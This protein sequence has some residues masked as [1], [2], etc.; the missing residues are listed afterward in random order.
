MGVLTAG[1]AAG[2]LVF[3]PL[4][5]ALSDRYGWRSVSIAVTAAV[6]AVIPALVL[7]LPE[8]PEGVG[9]TPLGAI[10]R[11]IEA[12]KAR[13]PFLIAIQGL[14]R[15]VK[16]LDFWLLAIAFGVCGLSTNG[17]IGTHMIAYCV[18]GGYTELA[19]SSIL[20]SFGIFNIIGSTAAG[21]LTDRADPRLL[22][23]YIFVLRGLS[24]L[25]LPYTDLGPLS[26]AAFAV[27]YG[28]EWIAT[29][30]PIFA[31]INEV[32]GKRDAPVIVS[33]IFAVHQIGGAGAALGA[34]IIR[35]WAGSYLLAFVAT[36]VACLATAVLVLRIAR[37]Q[38]ELVPAT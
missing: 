5:G 38:R 19:A 11:P 20:A 36:G 14:A 10:S 15:G 31:L 34:G 7:L 6:A 27:F 23:C 25:I 26:L 28:L 32:F 37:P 18:D 21:W 24:L 2:Q 17:L 4:L 16:S 22:L 13:N 8:S 12:P 1:I 3:L 33:W 29:V 9:L 35:N 30:P